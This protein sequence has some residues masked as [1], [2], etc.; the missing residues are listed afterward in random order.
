MLHLLGAVD[1][2]AHHQ[3]RAVGVLAE[4]AH[5]LDGDGVEAPAAAGDR[6]EQTRQALGPVLEELVE[7]AAQQVGLGREVVQ[8]RR[9]LD[10]D[11]VGDLL[12]RGGVEA[13]TGEATG[14]DLQDVGAYVHVATVRFVLDYQMVV[15][16]ENA[17]LRY[18]RRYL[19]ASGLVKPALGLRGHH[20]NPRSATCTFSTVW[21]LVGN[22]AVGRAG[23]PVRARELRASRP[24]RA[25]GMSVSSRHI[26]EQGATLGAIG[27]VAWLSLEQQ[28]ARKAPAQ[29]A[30]P[31]HARSHD[32]GRLSGRAAPSWCATTSATSGG[33]PACLQGHAA[34]AHVSAVG[35]RPRRARAGGRALPHVARAQRRLQPGDARAASRPM[36]PCR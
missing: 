35:L 14:R 11:L 23:G 26:L 24:W 3:P 6:L 33:D 4:E 31:R 8:Q 25:N 9:L 19:C 29:D 15:Q 32:R 22:R 18:Y 20:K 21:Q 10:P 17:R 34:A 16:L 27:R 36:S 7:H 2:L 5:E 28:R 13:L 30:R 1:Q 12:Q